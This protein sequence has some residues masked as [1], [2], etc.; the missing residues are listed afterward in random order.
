MCGFAGFLDRGGRCTNF[1]ATLQA[2]TD[3]IVHRGPDDS[4]AWH[5]DAARIGLGFRRLSIQDLSPLGHQ[6]MASSSNRFTMAFNGEVYNFLE[7]RTELEALGARFRGHSDTEV[8]LAAF[9]AWG[10]RKAT[11]RFIGMFAFAVWDRA[12]RELTIVRDRVGVKPLY[13]GLTGNASPES[14]SFAIPPGESLVFGSELKPFRRF[15]GMRFDVDQGAVA[16][17]VRY[18]YVPTPHSIHRTIRKLPPGHL[19]RVRDGKA[20]LE[21]WWSAKSVVEQAV[22]NPFRGSDEEAIEALDETLREAV[23]IRMI[24]DVPLGAFLSGGIDSSAVVAAM[25]ANAPGRVRSFT[26]GVRDP[27]YDEA[28]FARAIARHLGTDHCEEYIEPQEAI[29]SIPRI[30]QIWD[31]PFADSSQIP[32][33]LVSKIAR[34]HVTVI[35]SGDGGD[36][37]FGGYYRYAWSRSLWSKL[38]HL[39]QPARSVAAGLL[40][41]VPAEMTN[42]AARPLMHL[43]PRRLRMN[44]AGDRA[45]KMAALMTAGDPWEL[46]KRLTSIVQDPGELLLAAHEPKVPLTDPAWLADV[47][48]F[49]TRMMQADVV[50]YLVD[51]ILVKVDRASMATSLE[52]REPLLDHRLLELA[53]RLPNHMKIRGGVTKWALREVLY[54]RVPKSFFDR[55]KQGFS[56]PIEQWTVGPLRDWVESLLSEKALADSGVWNTAAVRRLW[57]SQL[58]GGRH[59]HQLWNVLMFQ[60]WQE[61]WKG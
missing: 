15:P 7:L 26:I 14:P 20:T 32:T 18:A 35:L 41:A 48:E 38:R 28:P 42:R 30:P 3:T 11:E 34:R 57:K 49:E 50:S 40:R 6:P 9:E 17:Y 24:A 60:A 44:A 16:L 53:F 37:L 25:T 13:Y 59:Q 1:V 55:P 21:Q 52:A 23:R 36:E 12:E 54:K 2:M 10:V 61:A 4:G 45:H 47:E 5:D 58:H 33:Y 27:T 56:I 22:A 8:M 46:F 51:D 43:M 31:E 19:L 29:D 39:P